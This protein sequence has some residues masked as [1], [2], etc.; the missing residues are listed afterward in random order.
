MA[1]RAFLP[2]LIVG[3]SLAALA[4]P[5]RTVI[6][7]RHAERAGGTGPEVGIS[8]AGRC[9]AEV[10]AGMLAD[11]GIGHIF[12]TEVGRTQQTASPLAK[13]LNLKPE[14]VPAKQTEVL[15]A[16]LRSLTGGAALVVGHSNT[17]PEI[18]EGLGAGTVA[19]IGDADYDRLFIATVTGP[20]EA[21]V[22]TLHYKGCGQ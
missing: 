14:V 12:T 2:L 10:L 7:V 17:V 15:V 20:K 11:A 8:D 19:P 9:R 6:L 13:R 21:S 22:I 4:Q 18:I 1:I 5:V 3:A 16:K